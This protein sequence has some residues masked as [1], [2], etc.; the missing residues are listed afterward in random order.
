MSIEPT[1]LHSAGAGL[2][3]KHDAAVIFVDHQ[4]AR[5]RFL[6]GVDLAA[7]GAAHLD[8][9]SL[10]DRFRLRDKSVSGRYGRGHP[11]DT[12]LFASL[13][14]VMKRCGMVLIVGPGSA[15]HE[16]VKYLARNN[17][18]VLQDHVVGV[19][20]LDRAT[21]GQLV[22][23]ARAAFAHAI[24]KRRPLQAALVTAPLPKPPALAQAAHPVSGRPEA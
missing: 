21:D 11:D 13:A 3:S 2:E 23:L 6:D 9:D 14:H 4:G 12:P 19:E 1:I 15:K 18:D 16:L 20:S 10:H 24:A 5:V 7:V 8:L 17:D 22:A